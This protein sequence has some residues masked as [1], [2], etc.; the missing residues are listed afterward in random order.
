MD[1]QQY[2][3]ETSSAGNRYLQLVMDRAGTFVLSNPLRTTGAETVP[4]K[5]LDIVMMFG[6]PLSIRG[7]LHGGFRTSPLPLA[8]GGHLLLTG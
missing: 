5:F 4:E 1:T 7:D 8:K 3:G 6:V 2:M